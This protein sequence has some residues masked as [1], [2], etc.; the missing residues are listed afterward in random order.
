MPEWYEATN[1]GIRFLPGI[2]A[3]ELAASQ[4]VFY[5]AGQYYRYQNGV[6]RDMEKIEAQRLVQSKMLSSETKML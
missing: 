1:A 6:Y 4:N 2:L 5:A 3:K